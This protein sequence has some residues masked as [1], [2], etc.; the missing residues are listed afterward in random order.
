LYD[1]V[2]D[3]RLDLTRSVTDHLRIDDVP[4]ALRRLETG[5]GDPVRMVVTHD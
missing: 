1:L 4:D 3:G 2:E 5:E